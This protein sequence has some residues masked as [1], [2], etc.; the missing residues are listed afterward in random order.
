MDVDTLA[1]LSA[2]TIGRALAAGAGCPVELT[3]CLLERVAANLAPLAIGSDTGGSVRIPAAFNGIAGYRPSVGRIATDGMFALSWTLDTVGPLA[4][5]VEDCVLAD[6]VL[7]GAT[8]CSAERLPVSRLR[9]FVPTSVVLDELEPAVEA[10]FEAA[11]ERLAA[12]GAEIERGECPALADAF[13]LSAELGT[14]AAAEAYV[15]H[16]TLMDGPDRNRIDRR[17]AARIERGRSMQASDL[18]ALRRARADGI[19][20]MAERLDGRFAAMPTCQMVAPEIAPLEA[21]ENRFHEVN[22][23]VLRNA[24]LG[25][26]LDMPGVAIP[27]GRDGDGMPTSF[28]LAAASGDDDRLLGAALGAEA[29]IRDFN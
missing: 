10:N 17:V 6:M 20:A 11:L 8:T 25:S 13:R 27:D 29:R 26:F 9:L 12:G 28:L 4:R 2:A 19:A 7:R 21:D 14:I 18:V 1:A 15:E 24:A 3:E 5:A 16:K 23:G 22:L